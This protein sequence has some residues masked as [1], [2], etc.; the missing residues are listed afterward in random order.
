VLSR[1]RKQE[2]H[3][4]PKPCTSRDDVFLFSDVL[5][6]QDLPDGEII[7]YGLFALFRFLKIQL[8]VKNDA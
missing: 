2:G 4:N 7:S 8:H 3:S 1:H 6:S 5:S